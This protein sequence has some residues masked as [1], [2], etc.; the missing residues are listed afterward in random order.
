MTTTISGTTGVSQCAP[1][2]VSQDDLASNV[3]GVGP[4]FSAYSTTNQTVT[5][6]TPAKIALQAKD[7]DTNNSF[8]NV[9]N[10]R[11]QP[12]VAGY[13]HVQVTIRMTSTS[14]PV[15]NAYVD[16]NKNGASWRR[17]NELTTPVQIQSTALVYLNGTTDY[18]EFIAIVGGTGTLS[19]QYVTPTYSC[20]ASGYLVRAA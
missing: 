8:D 9:T 13:Y 1:S 6:N 12:N 17:G 20:N 7:F 19:L 4:A 5:N 10:Y 16:I 11:F 3:V 15:A 18:V 2:S 14:L